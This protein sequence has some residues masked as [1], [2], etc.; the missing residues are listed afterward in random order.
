MECILTKEIMYDAKQTGYTCGDLH[1]RQAR[2]MCKVKVCRTEE[3]R[4][5]QERRIVLE[6]SK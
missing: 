5:S 3:R 2:L 6:G 4:N 1:V